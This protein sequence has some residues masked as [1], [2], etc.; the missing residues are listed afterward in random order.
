MLFCSIMYIIP[1][2]LFSGLSFQVE[3]QR[4]IK[5]QFA[6][7]LPA[8]DPFLLFLFNVMLLIYIVRWN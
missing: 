8:K 1:F 3:K 5:L 7:L 4:V 6:F 2:I